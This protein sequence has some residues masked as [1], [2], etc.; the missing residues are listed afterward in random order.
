VLL[1]SR[2]ANGEWIAKRLARIGASAY[3]AAMA[4]DNSAVIVTRTELVR[5]TLN[6]RVTVLHR[7]QWDGWFDVAEGTVSP[8]YPGSLTILPAG[9]MLIGM[10]AAVIRLVPRPRGFSE[11]WLVPAKCVEGASRR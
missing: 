5:V 1:V 10:R 9:E 7:G 2:A 4:T 6:G 8:F 11:E 3:A